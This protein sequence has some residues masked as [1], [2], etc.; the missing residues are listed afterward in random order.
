MSN[1][2]ATKYFA[3]GV[4]AVVLTFGAYLIGKSN[5]DPAAAG[6]NA[7]APAAQSAAPQGATPQAGQAPRNGQAPPGFGTAV[8]AA[9]PTKK[10]EAAV[11]GQVP[12]HHR[13]RKHAIRKGG[14]TLIGVE[15]AKQSLLQMFGSLPFGRM[16]CGPAYNVCSRTPMRAGRDLAGTP[17]GA[18]MGFSA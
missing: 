9:T 3:T 10:V 18:A 2:P 8:S 4:A 5:T 15:D 13:A 6:T 17:I 11:S 1:N 7:S 14:P 12:G 16:S